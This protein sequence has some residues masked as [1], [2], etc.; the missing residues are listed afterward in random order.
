ML[1]ALFFC[2]TH[3]TIRFMQQ[4]FTTIPKSITGKEELVVIPR[5]EYEELQSRVFPIVKLQKKAAQRLDR[6][7]RGATQEHSRGASAHLHAFLKREYPN[8]L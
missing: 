7:V 8:L 2:I 6:R 4:T 5:K 3:D 1:C